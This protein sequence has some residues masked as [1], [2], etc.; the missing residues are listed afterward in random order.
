MTKA[1]RIGR[2]QVI[3]AAGLAATVGVSHA[4]AQAWPAKPIRLVCSYAAGGGA[5]TMARLV[6]PRLGEALGQQ[7]VVENRAGAGGVVG[8]DVVAKSAPDGYT[9]LVDAAS[10]GVNPGFVPKMPFDTLKDLQSVSLL[11]T[12]PNVL[13]VHPS[14]PAQTFAEW[15]ALMKANPGKFSYG[16]AGTGSVQN[17][18]GEL[19]KVQ[20]GLFLVH[21]PYRG[22]APAMADLMANQIPM[23][24]GSMASA[25][26]N[27]RS[28]RMRPVALTGKSRSAA[29]PNMPTVKES[30]GPLANYEVYEWN[31]VFA[32]TGTPAPVVERMSREIGRILQ[33]PESRE[34]LAGLSAEPGGG[35]PAELERFRRAEIERWA[36]IVKRA[37]LKP[38]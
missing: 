13:A 34:R 4:H 33:L 8:G 3:Q 16:S 23:Y 7:V 37:G 6:A 24:F 22:G 10:H 21:I 30:G 26:P 5:D 11:A 32:P 35:T 38:D 20:A 2:R 12:V 1:I 9:F 19:L 29:F 25:T 17:M 15:L 28:G 18:A 31:A 14:F 36:G 27:L